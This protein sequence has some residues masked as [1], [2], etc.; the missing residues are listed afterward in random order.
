VLMGKRLKKG[1]PETGPRSL[2]K[3]RGLAVRREF[4]EGSGAGS[5]RKWAGCDLT[6][7]P[8]KNTECFHFAR[9]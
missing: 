5:N 3:A 6:L 8:G 4:I 2:A 9:Q 1:Q 7:G